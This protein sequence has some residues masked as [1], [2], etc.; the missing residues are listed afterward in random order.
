M[1]R[2]NDNT[3]PGL[4]QGSVA[5]SFHKRSEFRYTVV[6]QFSRGNQE[7][8]EVIPDPDSLRKEPK[9]IGVCTSRGCL[10]CH[11]VF[12]SAT[13]VFIRSFVALK[14]NCLATECVV[15]H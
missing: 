11:S 6:R 12:I 14:A 9:F 3:S 15:N 5:P 13:P 1:K 7:I 2:L 8:R 10:K 4:G